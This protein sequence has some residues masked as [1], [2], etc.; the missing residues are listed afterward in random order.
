MRVPPRGSPLRALMHRASRVPTALASAASVNVGQNPHC[1]S[2]AI[3][4]R[5]A[6]PTWT[7]RAIPAARCTKRKICV[8]HARLEVPLSQTERSRPERRRRPRGSRGQLIIRPK[9]TE[10]AAFGQ[11][12]GEL[13]RFVQMAFAGRKRSQCQP[14]HPGAFSSGTARHGGT[15]ARRVPIGARCS[16]AEPSARARGGRHRRRAEWRPLPAPLAVRRP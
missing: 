13:A 5:A 14:H 16:A 7:V 10:L 11:R 8:D 1:S 2:L 15:P 6:P 4:W 12:P 3:R 9:P